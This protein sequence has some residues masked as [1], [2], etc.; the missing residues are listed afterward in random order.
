VATLQLAVCLSGQQSQAIQLEDEHKNNPELD[1]SS[2]VIDLLYEDAEYQA[3]CKALVRALFQ[4]KLLLGFAVRQDIHKLN[5]WLHDTGTVAAGPLQL[6]QGDVNKNA[7]GTICISGR[8]RNILDVQQLCTGREQKHQ[9]PGLAAC[10]S[11]F[12]KKPLCKRQQC[13]DWGQRPLTA[14]QLEYAGLDA[15]ILLAL[16]AEIY[17]QAQKKFY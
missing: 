4:S 12:A 6:H 13:S 8:A 14:Q 11:R 5:R 15:A 10:V 9:L 3:K 1:V 7:F 17:R 2:W 16:V